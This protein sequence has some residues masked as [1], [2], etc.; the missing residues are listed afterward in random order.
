LLRLKTRPQK[1]AAGFAFRDPVR[2][3]NP[4]N[5]HD[6]PDSRVRS[7]SSFESVMGSLYQPKDGLRP[8]R[9]TWHGQCDTQLAARP[10][11]D[12]HGTINPLEGYNYAKAR[13][14]LLDDESRNNTG[15]FGT[16][17]EALG[18][19][20]SGLGLANRGVT[21][22][23]FLAP[24]AGL[25]MRSAAS[26]IDSAVRNGFAGSWDGH[27]LQERAENATRRAG[28]GALLGAA[29]PF[30]PLGWSGLKAVASPIISK[31]KP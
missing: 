27:G 10:V 12:K 2:T 3:P 6:I 21:A 30:L 31:F 9:D 1:C 28:Y 25:L 17:L 23:R 19:V 13:E 20:G 15:W 7:R 8:R 29:V 24:Q 26:A 16:G 22:A 11:R 4:G 14:D 5:Y 18:G